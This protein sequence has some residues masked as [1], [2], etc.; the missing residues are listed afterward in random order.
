MLVPTVNLTGPGQAA[1]VST[2]GIITIHR[3]SVIPAFNQGQTELY[4]V[5]PLFGTANQILF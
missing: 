2:E 1:P 4:Q 5:T 3:F